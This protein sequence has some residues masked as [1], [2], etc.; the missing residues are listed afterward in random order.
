MKKII[1]YF[2][3]REPEFYI[4]LIYHIIFV[5]TLT[6]SAWALLMLLPHIAVLL[7]A[8]YVRKGNDFVTSV[9][10]VYNHI[11][12]GNK[13]KGKDLLYQLVIIKRFKKLYQK[14]PSKV[15]YLSNVDYG[16]G[17]QEFNPKDLELS[18]K[19]GDKKHFNTYRE[20]IDATLKKVPKNDNF[21]GLDVYLSDGGIIMPSTEDVHLN[22]AYPTFPIA[23]ALSR[24]L[25]D[26]LIG[27][28]T[29][30]LGRV[31]IKLREQQEAY[32]KCLGTVPL[33]KSQLSK[34]WKYIPYARKWIFVKVRYYEKYESAERGLLPF[35]SLNAL[36]QTASPLYLTSGTAT[37]K[38]YESENGE[39]KEVL[40]GIRIE[41][42]KYDTRIFHEKM[43]G[44]TYKQWKQ[45]K[46]NGETISLKTEEKQAE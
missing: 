19:I 8:L 26:M 12:F 42:I 5:I 37:K 39:I 27:L 43:F 9:C 14:D 2:K 20:L 29:Q 32:L 35:N 13:G 21:E 10:K 34:I 4:T 22:K 24:Q 36:G 25:Y 45:N 7:F 31:W 3:T 16:Y 23:F 44:M 15:R 6:R 1:N 33:Y 40:C 11:V 46:K 41:D 30:A 38:A 17:Y 28:N 18:V